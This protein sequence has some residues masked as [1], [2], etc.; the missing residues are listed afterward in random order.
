MEHP[1]IDLASALSLEVTFNV[2]FDKLM[3]PRTRDKSSKMA[4]VVTLS[5]IKSGPGRSSTTSE[6]SPI[7]KELI[8]GLVG[9]A[10]AGVSLVG[11]KI[12]EL[13]DAS[14]Y[15]PIT[16]KLSDLIAKRDR[17]GDVPVV[18]VGP[19]QGQ[20]KLARARYLQD[21]GDNLRRDHQPHAVAALAIREIMERRKPRTPGQ[22]KIAFI[23][24]SIKH[25]SEV[26]L[27]REVY[28][29][30]FRLVAIHCDR[31]T[32][33][34]RL[35]GAPAT[36]AKY[37]G[38]HQDDVVQYMDRDE[39]DQ[40]NSYGQQVRDAFF[41]ADFFIDNNADTPEGL[42][43]MRGI[44][45]FIDLVMGSD[46]VRPTKH[47]IGMFH[48]HAAALQSS[49]LSRQ[50]GA[51]LLTNDGRLISTGTNDVPRFG[52]GV[53]SE[54]ISPDHRC[55]KWEYN[56]GPHALR[57]QA[58]TKDKTW[59]GCHN[60]RK[61]ELLRKIIAEYISEKF[62]KKFAELAHP[63]PEDSQDIAEKARNESEAAIREYL[64]RDDRIF[65]DLPG[66]KDIIEY[67]RS[68]HAEMSAIL[69][70]TRSGI[71]TVGTTLY[72]TTFP[73]HNCA[74]HLVAAGVNVIYYIEPYVKSLATE[75]HADSVS[76][77]G[78]LSS[79]VGGRDLGDS[80]G[81]NKMLILP[82]T[83]AGPRMYED[84]FQKRGELKERYTGR[85]C[86][87]EGGAPTI[88]VRLDKLHSVEEAAAGLIP[89]T[90]K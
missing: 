15:A 76:T 67:S 9:Y 78:Q 80:S 68:I 56:L 19:K 89:D 55:H 24:D 27:L 65:Y 72:C 87:P 51:A 4:E 6:L 39:K 31:S 50:V 1:P 5:A 17:R 42:R 62:S 12:S 2:K 46:L 26:H 88:A 43:L 18:S 7:S 10:G 90:E 38:A 36:S 59:S 49:C 41:L 44:Q 40:D 8:I 25:S 64:I 54:G 86:K 53:Y 69:N 81:Q 45:R 71:P 20:E 77:T 79:Q 52:G 75:L 37:R 47:E 11:Q 14:G 63:K 60:D 61:K 29:K 22:D 35:I 28:D 21:L 85:Y 33:E 58:G 82:F 32:R 34:R 70:A 73:C 83:G 13:L 30:S 16:I 84:F 74:R 3:P 23:L 57:Q 48:A 66:I